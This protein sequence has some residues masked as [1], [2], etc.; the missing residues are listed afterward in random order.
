MPRHDG[1]ADEQMRDLKIAPHYLKNPKGSVLIEVGQTRVIC[2]ASVEERVPPFLNGSGEGWVTAEYSML[3]GS[4][5]TRTQREVSRGKASGRTLE[6]QRLIGR[7]LRGVVDRRALGERTIW[8]DCDVIQ[9]DGG[10]RTASVTGG[11]VAM[12]LAMAKL[13]KEGRLRKPTLSD[14]LAAISVGIVENRP[15][16]DLDYVEDSAAAVD[17]NVVGLSDGSYVEV[18]GDGG[19]P[20]LHPR[21]AGPAARPGRLRDRA[22]DRR[23]ARGDREPARRPAPQMKTLVVATHNQGKI[24]E[25]A[26]ALASVEIELLGLDALDDSTEVEETGTTFEQNAKL[27]AEGYSLRTPHLVLAEDSGIEVDALGGEPGVYSARYG[28]SGL[29]DT[30]RNMKLLDALQGVVDEKRTARYRSVI[31]IAREGAT[32]ATFDGTCEGRILDTP[33]G[34]QGFGYDP[35]FLH[36]EAGCFG[37]ISTA[38]KRLHSH[39]GQAIRAFLEALRGGDPRIC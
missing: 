38:A 19:E 21:R 18:Q 17:M 2:T 1:R 36:A 20:A 33:R 12:A 16:L 25:L 35:V 3:P 10:T 27:K 22:A 9:A 8:V 31:A 30:D 13:Q 28:G 24:R 26:E 15:V 14:L 11:Y 23:P 29:S 5:G 32:L 4:T 6:I 34:D 7:A 39:R 37:E